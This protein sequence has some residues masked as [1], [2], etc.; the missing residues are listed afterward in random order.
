MAIMK[1]KSID[2]YDCRIEKLKATIKGLMAEKRVVILRN[3]EK[4]L[5]A[6]GKDKRG[7]VHFGGYWKPLKKMRAIIKKIPYWIYILVRFF[8]ALLT[9]LS[10]LGWLES[11]KVFFSKLFTHK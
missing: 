5:A 10:L 8:A 11:F 6:K 7:R 2:Y 4:E 1:R 9:C 3:C